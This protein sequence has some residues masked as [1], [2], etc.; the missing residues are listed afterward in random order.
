MLPGCLSED[1]EVNENAGGD[2]S[3]NYFQVLHNMLAS[4]L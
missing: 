3:H 2:T 1:G 4:S